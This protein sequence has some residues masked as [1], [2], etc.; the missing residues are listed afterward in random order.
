MLGLLN[1]ECQ[2]MELLNYELQCLEHI[3]LKFQCL[4]SLNP[5]FQ[6]FRTP[7]LELRCNELLN[8]ESDSLIETPRP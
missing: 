4:Q 6:S 2:F 1:L 3:I 5:K 8:R 7:E